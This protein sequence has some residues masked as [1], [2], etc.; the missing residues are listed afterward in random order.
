MAPLCRGRIVWATVPDP[1]GSNPKRRPL[2]VISTDDEIAAGGVMRA[3]AVS[4]LVDPA[5]ADV[6]VPLPWDRAGHPR[7]RLRTECVAVC[8]WLVRLT[9]DVIEE[10]A[11]LVP[12]RH[13]R[14]IEDIVRRL[15]TDPQ[16]PAPPPP[17]G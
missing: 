5:A 9:A 11:G 17:P 15:R 6:C 8:T 16:P 1:R 10:A 12:G 13:L 14:Q 2:V 3:V 4:T 7:T